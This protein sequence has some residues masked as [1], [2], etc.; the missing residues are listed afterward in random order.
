MKYFVARIVY[1][2]PLEEVEK[3]IEE[4]RQFLDQG[5]ERDWFLASGPQEPKEGGILIARAPERDDLEFFLQDD[6]FVVNKIAEY[7]ITEFT[8][9]KRHPKMAGFFE[10]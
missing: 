8:P 4:H 6:P 1:I 10:E 9:V 5:Y 2:A 3:V 7:Q